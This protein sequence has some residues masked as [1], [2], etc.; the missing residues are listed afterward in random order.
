MRF[1]GLCDR[2]ES[3]PRV[4]PCDWDALPSDEVLRGR[5]VHVDFVDERPDAGRRDVGFV[6]VDRLVP[7]LRRGVSL[8]IKLLVPTNL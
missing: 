2:V 7:G 4:L 5:C 3:V 8:L 6:L 1:G